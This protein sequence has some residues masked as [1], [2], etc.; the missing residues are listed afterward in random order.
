MASL[1]PCL[2]VGLLPD[3]ATR[4]VIAIDG[5][6]VASATKPSSK[7]TSEGLRT[8]FRQV[9]QIYSGDLNGVVF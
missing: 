2:N 9:L 4:E 3:V 1:V 6:R 8:Q 7:T 5:F